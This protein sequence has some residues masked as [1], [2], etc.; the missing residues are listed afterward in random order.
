V[1]SSAPSG[2]LKDRV[3]R[4]LAEEVGP[5]LHLDGADLEVLDVSDGVVRVRLHGACGGCPSTIMAVI[6][7]IEQELRRLV[8]EV[9]YLEAVP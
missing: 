5:A 8:P 4:A 2:D 1:T 9:E 3:I 6:M 7:G